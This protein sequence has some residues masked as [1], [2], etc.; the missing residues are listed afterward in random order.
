MALARDRPPA[1]IRE[2][3]LMA[4]GLDE[5]ASRA[6]RRRRAGWPIA[7]EVA[8][9]CAPT[10][11]RLARLLRDAAVEVDATELGAIR[12][13]LG[14]GCGSPLYRRDPADAFLAIAELEASVARAGGLRPCR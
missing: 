4:C 11:E 8:T 13:F 6:R 3:R 9:A 1:D 5:L 7:P 10:A 12:T 14:D 2:R